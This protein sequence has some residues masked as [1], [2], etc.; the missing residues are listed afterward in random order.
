MPHI[1][2]I[3]RPIL[4]VAFG[5][6]CGLVLAS[7][8]GESPVHVLAILGRSAFGT[9]YDLGMS[10][11]F[12]TPLVLTGLAVALPYH[13][14]LFNVGGEG[15][16]I[17]GVFA[18][19]AVGLLWPEPGALVAKLLTLV[20]AFTAGA[21]WGAIPGWM[22][23]RRGAHEVITT[24]MM[25]FIAI[26]MTSW[27]T[28]GALRNTETMN[29]ETR[30]VGA[31]YL[32]P[33]LELFGDAPLSV[34]LLL[35]LVAA[36]CVYLLVWKTPFG[37][38]LRAVGLN[39]RAADIAGISVGRT[40]ILAMALGGGLAGLAAVGE[41]FGN[42]GKFKIGFSAEYGF[43]GIAVALL[44]RGRPLGVVLAAILFGALHKGAGDLDFETEFITRD[45]A[46]VMQSLVII[47]VAVDG[48]W[49]TGKGRS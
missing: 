19:A 45:L 29:P 33:R 46:V 26:G 24:I 36:A 37:G 6:A 16:M 48:F 27:L 21:L 40:R 8:A 17:V 43:T 41:I 18:A 13:S 49:R 14:G 20:A 11:Y 25:N 39:E 30:Q 5:L 23:V 42:S 28:L 47:A 10:L 44:A 9:P 1:Q 35:G 4:A 32:W 34:A 7:F 12:A 2:T 31:A 22:R 3:L 38:E 15:Q